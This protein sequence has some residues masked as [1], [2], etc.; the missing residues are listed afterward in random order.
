MKRRK[1]IAATR[2]ELAEAMETLALDTVD[3]LENSSDVD[4]LLRNI[5]AVNQQLQ[6]DLEHLKQIAEHA[7]K[8]AAIASGMATVVGKLLGF[9]NTLSQSL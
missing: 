1:E 8:A 2:G 7:A 5:E 3:A 4:N 9:K 6:D